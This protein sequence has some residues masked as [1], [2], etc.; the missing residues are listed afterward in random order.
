MPLKYRKGEGS[1]GRKEPEHKGWGRICPSPRP[2]PPMAQG[3]PSYP[4]KPNSRGTFSI[5]S[6]I[7]DAPCVK[8]SDMHPYLSGAGVMELTTNE[9]EIQLAPF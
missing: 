6:Q 1:K 3:S 4:P 7:L 9:A 2:P 5:L 8:S